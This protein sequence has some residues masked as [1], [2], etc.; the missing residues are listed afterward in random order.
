MTLPNTQN[1][2]AGDFVA[3]IVGLP[4]PDIDYALCIRR[5]DD[6]VVIVYQVWQQPGPWHEATE[7][8]ASPDHPYGCW[9][10]ERLDMI[11]P[12][13]HTKRAE[14]FPNFTPE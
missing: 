8:I 9:K 13:L 12:A 14:L 6:K 5:D 2:Q 4:G 1:P 10:T 11:G 3:W 7:C